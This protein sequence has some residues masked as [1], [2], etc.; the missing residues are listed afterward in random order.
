MKTCTGLLIA[1]VSALIVASAYA[2]GTTDQAVAQAP[3]TNGHS[4]TIRIAGKG[5]PKELA[6]KLTGDQIVELLNS[7]EEIPKLAPL[8]ILI[9]F[10][11]VVALVTVISVAQHRRNA[12]LHRTLAAMIEKG[13]PIPPELLQSPEPVKRKRSDLHR[14]LVACGVGIGL[15][16]FLWIQGGGLIVGRHVGGLWAVGFIPLFI[17][18][19]HLISW[20]LE[21]RKPNS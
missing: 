11:F 10:L 15:I 5:I 16:L 12:M 8:I 13:V 17:G 9:P 14:G 21:Q 4:A 1:A 18:I 3:A 19:G 20:K 6:E 7:R 2:A